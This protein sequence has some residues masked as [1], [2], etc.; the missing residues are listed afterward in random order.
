MLVV[1]EVPAGTTQALK[2]EVM[3]A[4]VAVA[5]VT[6]Q[7]RLLEAVADKLEI[8]DHRGKLVAQETV[9]EA[10]L[11]HKLEV[12]VVVGHSLLPQEAVAVQASL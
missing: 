8:M 6:E 10:M 2:T 11:V 3:A 1:A 5:E 4:K 9:L 12:A 7:V